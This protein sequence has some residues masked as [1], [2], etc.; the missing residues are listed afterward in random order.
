MVQNRIFITDFQFQR[1]R[2]YKIAILQHAEEIEGL[3]AWGWLGAAEGGW[4]RLAG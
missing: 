2:N 3:T 1:A 4:L